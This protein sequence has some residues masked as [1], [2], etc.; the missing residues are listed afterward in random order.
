MHLVLLVALLLA[1]MG[2]GCTSSMVHFPTLESGKPGDK[3]V[4][5]EALF[6]RPSGTGPFPA[7]ILL[8]GCGGMYGSAKQIAS[9]QAEW[10][11]ILRREGYAVLHVDSFN[12][13]GFREVCAFKPQPVQ[14]YAH[15]AADTRAALRWLQTQPDVKADRIAVLGWSHGGQT[16]LNA[17][18]ALR[19]PAGKAGGAPDFRVAVSFYPLCTNFEKSKWFTRVPMMLLI[20]ELD[21]W[22]PAPPCKGLAERLKTIGHPI[23]FVFYP[24]AYHGFDAPGAPIRV[25]PNAPTAANGA[26]ATV[27]TNPAARAD[28][29][30]RVPAYLAKHL[31]D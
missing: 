13:R 11:G 26:T 9:R 6:E 24:G 28:A 14:P 16:V 20:G 1:G 8:H 18:D 25:I 23:D 27:G 2:S 5:L 3:P 10:A 29:L 22:T 17:V 15:R 31:K 30:K 4:T 12:P 21:D 7:V 19:Y